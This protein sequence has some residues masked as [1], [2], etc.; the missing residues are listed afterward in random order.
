DKLLALAKAHDVDV[1]FGKQPQAGLL[2][3][4]CGITRENVRA[5][6]FDVDL[7][8]LVAERVEQRAGIGGPECGRREPLPKVT[9]PRRAVGAQVA[10]A[11]LEQRRSLPPLG[12]AVDP[13]VR[14]R[15]GDLRALRETLAELREED[16]EPAG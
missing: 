3:G 6:T 15:E 9:R 7:F 14:S 4:K 13:L 16:G 12:P 2:R 8:E 1:V 5:P 10:P 11:D